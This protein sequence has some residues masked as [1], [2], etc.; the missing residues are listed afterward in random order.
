MKEE[1]S[2]SDIKRLLVEA[3]LTKKLAFFGVVVSTVATLTAAVCIPL[4]YTYA[5]NAQST[6][7][8]EIDF[9]SQR[10]RNLNTEFESVSRSVVTPYAQLRV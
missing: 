5:Q 4:L 8:E 2:E 7:R 3:D 10:T 6:M 1:Y 9:C